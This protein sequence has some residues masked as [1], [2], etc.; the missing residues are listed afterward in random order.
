MNKNCLFFFF[1][2]I[3]HFSSEA[4]I[5][6]KRSDG[7]NNQTNFRL[8]FYHL[9]SYSKENPSLF[10]E[11]QVNYHFKEYYSLG[12]G[13]GMNL[14]PAALAFPLYLEGQRLINIGGRQFYFTQSYGVNLKLG[15]LSFFSHRYNGNFNAMFFFERKVKLIAGLGYLYLWDNYGGKNV[16]FLL[17]IG[18]QY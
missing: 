4:Q 10:L 2:I 15:D 9:G 17:N 8:G 18:V 6:L 12:L 5:S 16:S 3:F 11:H 14:Y 7:M 13:V 1:V